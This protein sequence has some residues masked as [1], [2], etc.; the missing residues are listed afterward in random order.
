MAEKK[1]INASRDQKEIILF[2]RE[3]PS[4]V[5]CDV[6]AV[7]NHRQLAPN[8]AMALLFH[9]RSPSSYST[10]IRTV[11]RFYSSKKPFPWDPYTAIEWKSAK[12]PERIPKSKGLPEV[13]MKSSLNIFF[14]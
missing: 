6:C 8:L 13:S 14:V 5:V 9:R 4:Q 10:C 3:F 1:D 12:T 11:L 7:N 2:S